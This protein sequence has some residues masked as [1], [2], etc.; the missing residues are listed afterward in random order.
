MQPPRM[1]QLEADEI[2]LWRLDLKFHMDE[3][4]ALEQTLGPEER[5]RAN[6]F[7]HLRERNRYIVS[8]GVL[9]TLLAQYLRADPNGLVF[10]RGVHGK[11]ELQA[12]D[13]RFNMSH[14]EDLALYAV[15]RTGPVG[16]DVECILPGV[17]EEVASGFSPRLT[18]HLAPLPLTARR[19]VFYRGWTRME[20]HAK[21]CGTGLHS[22]I[23]HLDRFL[24]PQPGHVPGPDSS[25]TDCQWFF[26]DLHPRKGYA[27]SLA[28]SRKGCRLKYW[29]VKTHS[30]RTRVRQHR[31]A[32]WV[33]SSALCR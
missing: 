21:G 12:G 19:R 11:P 25:G 2:H 31:Q 29:K 28:A 7:V 3:L 22:N 24:D 32:G 17:D 30:P 26:H 20:A 1:L 6:R 4:H 23:D 14:S 16:I 33:P 13:L 27:G 18:S 5:A 9:R 10:R 8:H 15:T